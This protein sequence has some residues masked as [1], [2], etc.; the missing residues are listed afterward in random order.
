MALHAGILPALAGLAGQPAV[1]ARFADGPVPGLDWRDRLLA[2]LKAEHVVSKCRTDSELFD[3]RMK[4]SERRALHEGL[5]V[6]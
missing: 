4:V 1:L 5:V 3:K 6:S 2:Y